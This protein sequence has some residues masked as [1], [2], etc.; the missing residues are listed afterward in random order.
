M[1]GP[2]TST[3]SVTLETTGVVRITVVVCVRV[4]AGSGTVSTTVCGGSVT[5]CAGRVLVFVTVV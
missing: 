1:V 4:T 2:G 5:V 3:L